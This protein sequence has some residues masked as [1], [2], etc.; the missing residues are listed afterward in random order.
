M[1]ELLKQAF[2]LGQELAKKEHEDRLKAELK[3]RTALVGWKE[4]SVAP[5]K[6]SKENK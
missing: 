3:K 1:N 5:A 4:K 2:E 6:L